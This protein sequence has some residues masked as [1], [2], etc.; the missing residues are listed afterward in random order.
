MARTS[1]TAVLMTQETAAHETALRQIAE[2]EMRLAVLQLSLGLAVVVMTPVLFRLSELGPT[3]TAFYRTALAIPL[4]A[5]WM[6][7]E[8]RSASWRGEAAALRLRRDGIAL[9]F[10]GLLFALNIVGYAWAVHFTSVANASLLSNVTPIFVALG[11]FLVFRER[12]SRGFVAA[13]AAAVAGV[14]ILTSNKLEFRSDQ[15]LGDALAL[16]DALFYA[17]YLMV[18]GRLRLRIS[19]ATIMTW[20]ASVAALGLLAT[21]LAAGETLLP[22]TLSGWAV[23]LTLSLVNYAMGQGFITLAMARIGAAFSSVAML[24]LPVGAIILAWIVLGEAPG[25]NQGIGGAIILASI[26]AARRASRR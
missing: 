14:V 2:R 9:F 4:F 19:A 12:V 13:I 18:I 8:R 16:A 11:N 5:G 26:Y 10:G 6:A 17:G 21:A 24:S 22:V 20:S 7:L 23:I 1:D 3:A 25:L 15:F